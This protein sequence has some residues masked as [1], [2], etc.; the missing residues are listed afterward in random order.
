V[1]NAA[2]NGGDGDVLA[3]L[4]LDPNEQLVLLA[5]LDL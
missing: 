3:R 1:V 5:V 4:V 2:S